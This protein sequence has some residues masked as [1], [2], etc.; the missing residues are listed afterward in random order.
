M[1]RFISYLYEYGQGR[2]IRNIGFAKVELKDSEGTIQVHGRGIRGNGREKVRVYLCFEQKGRCMGILQGELAH[3]EPAVDYR[4]VYTEHDTGGQKNYDLISGIVLKMG[5]ENTYAALWG[6][7]MMDPESMIEWSEQQKVFPLERRETEAGTAEE[8]AEEPIREAHE[9]APAEE[10][11]EKQTEEPSEDIAV[12]E[13]LAAGEKEMTAEEENVKEEVI[14]EEVIQEESLQKEADEEVI[15]GSEESE[16]PSEEQAVPPVLAKENETI[17]RQEESAEVKESQS[18]QEETPTPKADD[19]K[20]EE[21]HEMDCE[22][23]VCIKMESKLWFEKITR[24]DLAKLPRCEWGNANNTFLLHGYRN[25]HHLLLIDDQGQLWLGVPGVYHERE[26]M[27]ASSC[28][29]PRF[30]RIETD[31]LELQKNERNDREDFGYWC[32]K[33][34]GR[35]Q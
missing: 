4:L 5:E 8:A 7:K 31:K 22:E 1:K 14:Q 32:R 18:A 24:E 21:L 6:E 15:L 2:K 13:P 33:V 16:I 10:E 35:R 19:V 11:T 20:T 27:A 28:G 30:W 9:T 29:F 25:Y 12:E 26:Q 17:M 3:T 23:S 34:R